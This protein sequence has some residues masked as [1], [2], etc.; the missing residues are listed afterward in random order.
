MHKYIPRLLEKY[1]ITKQNCKYEHNN[2]NNNNNPTNN[3][4]NNPTEEFSGRKTEM[5]E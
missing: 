3:N 5:E 1:Q 4:N 2:N